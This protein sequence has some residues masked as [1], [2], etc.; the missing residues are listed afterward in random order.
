ME[1]ATQELALRYL[2]E[3]STDI[4]LALMV[5]KNGELAASAPDQPNER[6]LQTCMDMVNEVATLAGDEGAT[7]L[8]LDVTLD[9]GAVFVAREGGA[10]L[11]CVTG[12]FALPGLILHDMRV[13]LEDLRRGGPKVAG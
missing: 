9:R 12:P 4:R 11:L 6:V 8:E 7:A 2:L 10:S 5:D 3:L 13:V 1:A